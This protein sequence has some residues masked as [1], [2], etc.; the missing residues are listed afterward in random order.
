MEL[1]RHIDKWLAEWK[2][3]PEH[4]P[5]LVR[6]I[7]QS[8]KTHSVIRFAESNYNVVIYLNFWDKPDLMMSL[9]GSWTLIQLYGSCL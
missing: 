6:G 9:T 8:G 4:K 2:D 7:R 5:A 3:N 1:K